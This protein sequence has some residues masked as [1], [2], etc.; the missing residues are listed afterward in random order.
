MMQVENGFLIIFNFQQVKPFTLHCSLLL[1][2]F[3]YAFVGGLIFN[4]LEAEAT[5]EHHRKSF[6]QKGNWLI[7]CQ[8]YREWQ[9]KADCV[10][11]V[12]LFFGMFFC[13]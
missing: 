13:V 11:R 6:N 4:R 3:G 1:L 12:I 2:I 7:N 10:F 9:A 8:I 5:E